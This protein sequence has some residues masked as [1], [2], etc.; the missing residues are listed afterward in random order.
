MQTVWNK[1][2]N[3]Y[4]QSEI[5]QQVKDLPVGIYKLE[6]GPFDSL[7]LSHLKDKFSFPYKI[8]GVETS[9]VKRVQKTWDNT[10]GN[11]GILLNG[12]KGTGK[13]VTAQIIANEMN[14]PVIVIDFE[15]PS[16]VGFLK[17]IQQDVVV[18][19]DE[20]EKIYDYRSSQLLTIMDGVLKNDSRM[21][22]LLTTNDLHVNENLLQR[23][24]R[25]RYLK[26]FKDMS[27]DVIHEVVKDKLI[28]L[29]L[30]NKVIE[31]ISQL[32]IITMDLVKSIVEEVN[33][34]E[35]EPNVFKS[36]F[37]STRNDVAETVKVTYTYNNVTKPLGLS[38]YVKIM[39]LDNNDCFMIDGEII[40][41]VLNQISENQYLV[42]LSS[43]LNDSH[44]YS[45]N[46]YTTRIADNIGEEHKDSENDSY[47]THD[48]VN[49]IVNIERER[50]LHHSFS[51]FA[52]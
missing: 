40:G 11:L 26:R 23:P 25:V 24:S 45:L 34:H 44:Y 18:F 6:K 13:T 28:H 36:Y 2:G 38:S 27:L 19:I 35:E 43:V 21:M 14:L 8:Y 49:I 42:K 4:S 41:N 15:H 50:T 39:T 9:F 17:S 12:V 16:V 52:L 51:K 3:S 47:Y 10:T 20:F 30:Y 31:Y 33:I 7:Y 1:S 37:N 48:S 32:P 29:H 5:T 22:F 46:S